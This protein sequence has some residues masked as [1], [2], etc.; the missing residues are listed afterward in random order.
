MPRRNGNKQFN[1][2]RNRG[3]HQRRRTTRGHR[4]ISKF[5]KYKWYVAIDARGEPFI[6]KEGDND[7]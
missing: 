4:K 3:A 1:Q 6:G 2:K 7:G 5:I